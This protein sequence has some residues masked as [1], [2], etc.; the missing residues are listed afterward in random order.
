MFAN[1]TAT[2]NA[3]AFI[4]ITRRCVLKQ[5]S[6]TIRADFD[7]DAEEY[8]ID[9]SHVPY[10]QG[11]TNDALGVLGVVMDRCNLVTAAGVAGGSQHVII[12][13]DETLEPGQRIYLNGVLAGTADVDISVIVTCSGGGM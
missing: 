6:I 7:A 2:A 8:V 9:I 3:L 4:E 1:F 12:P 13:C 10:F 5:L 11:G